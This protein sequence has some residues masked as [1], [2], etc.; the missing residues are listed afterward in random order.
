[1]LL[2]CR[3]RYTR[4]FNYTGGRPELVGYVGFKYVSS[5]AVR[6]EDA[7]SLPVLGY[8]SIALETASSNAEDVE[9][10]ID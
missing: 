1:M 6:A 8:D 10:L 9:A 2:S 3:G 4:V 7:A 5:P